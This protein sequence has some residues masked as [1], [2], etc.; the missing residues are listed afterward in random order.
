QAAAIVPYLDLLGVSDLYLSPVLAAA[1]GST[2]GYDVVDHGRLNPELGGEEGY[3]K[4]AAACRARG[5]GLLLDYVPN[6]MGIGRWNAWWMDLL[7]NG[8]SA[9]WAKAFD[10]DWRP[11]KAELAHKVLVPILGGQ[12]GEVL[13]RGELK[14]K[15]EEG[16][17]VLCY[18]DHRF[19][20]APRQVP[21]VLRHRLDLLKAEAGPADVHVQELES[22]CTALEKLAPRTET[23]RDAVAERAREK[24][25]AK[26]RLAALCE[27]S[28]R[29]RGFV[30][31]NV[32]IFNGTPG[33]PRSFDLL[34]RLL[35]A[36][37]YRLAFWRVAGEEINYR[38]FFDVNGLA[39]LRMEE[40]EVFAEAHR[41]VLDLVVSGRASGL[42][43]D[44]PDGLYAPS[45][46]FRRLQASYLV[47]RARAEAA[48]RGEPLD[49]A[50]EEALL[51]R[52][53]DE[54]EAG[55]FE[56]PPMYVVVEKVLVASETM[57]DGWAVDGTTGYEFLAAVNGLFVER[58]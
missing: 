24:E 19:P 50:T 14:L 15:R 38:R 53:F 18:Y 56:R 39:A 33:D 3:A 46:Y 40:P 22:I 44:H 12:Y 58:E 13:E 6:H 21:V 30:D 34:D 10:V 55:R 45:A 11:V 9:V 25:V 48:R 51:D 7:E 29:I 20:I 8:P 31:E 37:A 36:Q 52:I 23:S 2:H 1:P 32:R 49:A 28:P 4:L 27:A 17:L 54:L 47:A 16:A 5:L 41:L 57:P 26:R 43:I 42:R 35:D